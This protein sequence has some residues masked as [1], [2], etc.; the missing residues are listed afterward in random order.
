MGKNMELIKVFIATK[1]ASIAY[2]GISLHL[3][4]G[5]GTSLYPYEKGVNLYILEAFPKKFKHKSP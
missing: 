2:L 4:F 1:S 5:F 3:F